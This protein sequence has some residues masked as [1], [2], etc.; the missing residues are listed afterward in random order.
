MVGDRPGGP[1]GQ[2]GVG[3]DVSRISEADGGNLGDATMICQGTLW[4]DLAWGDEPSWEG[5]IF[6]Q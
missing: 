1:R 3:V 2:D 5:R 4:R 6:G